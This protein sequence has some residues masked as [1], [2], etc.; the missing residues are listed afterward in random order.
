MLEID[1]CHI[2]L[3][4]G[5]I[6]AQKPKNVVELGLG[7]GK[8][9]EG[10]L[11]ALNYNGEDYKYILV[12]SGIDWGTDVPEEKLKFLSNYKNTGFCKANEID[13][14]F[15]VKETFDFILSDAD[16][17][18]TDKWFDY[19]YDRLLNKGGILVYHDVS[20]GHEGI[21]MNFPNLDN[22]Y[23]RCKHLNLNFRHFNKS[24][25]SDEECG[26]GLLVIFK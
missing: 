17:W 22:I 16:H 7:S 15:N 4:A 3:I 26:R 9:S 14:V 10:I 20:L 5:L 24:S 1:K 6:K 19:V 21:S 18:N 2:D 8:S 25:R 23:H 13:F 12:D 11:E